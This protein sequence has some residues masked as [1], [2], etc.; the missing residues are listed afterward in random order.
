M[1]DRAPAVTAPDRLAR[2]LFQQIG[3]DERSGI[4][5][6]CRLRRSFGLSE[7]TLRRLSSEAFGFGPKTLDQI[8][9]F[10]RFMRL[11]Q[12]SRRDRL[13]ELAVEA[14]YADQPHL[15]RETRRLAGL[16]PDAIRNQLK[17]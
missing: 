13:A 1:L 10:Q 3:Q 15:T 7:R 4:P 11:A 17:V 14:G 9:R 8:L 5:L 12:E 16:T 2:A 6:M